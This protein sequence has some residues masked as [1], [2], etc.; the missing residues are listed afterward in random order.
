MIHKEYWN[1][2]YANTTRNDSTILVISKAGE[3]WIYDSSDKSSYNDA[4]AWY[5]NIYN[6]STD[7]TKSAYVIGTDCYFVEESSQNDNKQYWEEEYAGST[8][9]NAVSTAV[10]AKGE[11]WSYRGSEKSRYENADA[12][13]IVLGNDE[14]GDMTIAYVKGTDCYIP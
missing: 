9:D 3:G 8:L 10:S 7:E 11:G 4:D 2:T 5:I 1:E 13:A 12:W 6:P 14:T